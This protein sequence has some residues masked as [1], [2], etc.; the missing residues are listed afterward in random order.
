MAAKDGLTYGVVGVGP[1][2][3]RD[4]VTLKVGKTSE[5]ASMLNLS[6]FSGLYYKHILTIISDDH[7]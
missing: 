3:A 4:D 5:L 1:A 6:L 7:K 2:P